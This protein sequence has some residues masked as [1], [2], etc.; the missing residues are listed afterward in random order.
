MNTD[1]DV[2][3]LLRGLSA[4]APL[5][6]PGLAATARAAMHHRRRRRATVLGSATA[7]LCLTLAGGMTFGMWD[8]Q[9]NQASVETSPSTDPD[10]EDR[11]TSEC[12]HQPPGPDSTQ[13]A[14]MS[15]AAAAIQR[16]WTSAG[17]PDGTRKADSSVP[18]GLAQGL[19]GQVGSA[20]QGF[21]VIVDP[22]LQDPAALRSRLRTELDVNTRRA[23]NIEA[24]CVSANHLV[25]ALSALSRGEWTANSEEKLSYTYRLEVAT[26]KVV[27]TLDKALAGEDVVEAAEEL[28]PGTIVVEDGQVSRLM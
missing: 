17:I 25:E 3:E 18:P 11:P 13:N 20:E 19:V 12:L 9:A 16:I 14:D 8:R 24:N 21:T 15:A 23:L 27:L 26:E 6:P 2:R 28:A 4:Q 7:V 10:S 5:P 22:S 1:Q